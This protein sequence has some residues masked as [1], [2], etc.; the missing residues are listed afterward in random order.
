MDKD[1]IRAAITAERDQAWRMAENALGQILQISILGP[2]SDLDI[3]LVKGC[4][5]LVAGELVSRIEERK[6]EEQS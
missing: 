1:S 3:E 6:R 5:A 4:C 2:Q